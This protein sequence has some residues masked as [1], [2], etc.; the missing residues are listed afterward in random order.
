MAVELDEG[1]PEP[2]PVCVTLEVNVVPVAVEVVF[3]PLPPVG[4]K[5]GKVVGAVVVEA[6]DETLG[7]R[8]VEVPVGR[9]DAE[10][11]ELLTETL[12]LLLLLL[13]ML[14]VVELEPAP[15][16][17]EAAMWNG[18]EYWKVAGFESRLIL[19]P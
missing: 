13:L 17:P 8:Y 18:N 6:V 19:K 9:S 5:V 16:A 1:V 4:V 10:V 3:T 11:A 2:V 12:A 14:V 15:P 7:V